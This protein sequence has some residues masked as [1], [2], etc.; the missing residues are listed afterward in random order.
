MMIEVTGSD[1]DGGGWSARHFDHLRLL[2]LLIPTFKATV[3]FFTSRRY[4]LHGAISK[5]FNSIEICNIYPVV[6]T[7]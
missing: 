4:F 3:S 6:P 5:E 7:H 2:L 1:K